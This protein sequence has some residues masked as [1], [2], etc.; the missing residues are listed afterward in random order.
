MSKELAD[1]MSLMVFES[2]NQYVTVDI[3]KRSCLA[4][5]V[6]K[7]TNNT[8]VLAKGILNKSYETDGIKAVLLSFFPFHTFTD[9]STIIKCQFSVVLVLN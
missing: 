5:S 2:P 7:R 3:Y 9:A 4:A 1:E 6:A 8:A